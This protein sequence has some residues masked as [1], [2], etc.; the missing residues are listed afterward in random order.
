MKCPA[1]QEVIPISEEDAMPIEQ[2]GEHGEGS[3]ED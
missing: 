1:W 2:Q 3:L